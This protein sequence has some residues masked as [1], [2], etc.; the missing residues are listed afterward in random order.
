MLPLSVVIIV[1][2]MLTYFNRSK[3]MQQ[4]KVSS[5]YQH[6]LLYDRFYCMQPLAYYP[7]T[8]GLL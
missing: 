6:Q 8:A 4:K 1:Y 2:A 7:P 3:Y 5:F